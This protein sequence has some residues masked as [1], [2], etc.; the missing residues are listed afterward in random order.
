MCR[1]RRKPMHALFP[2]LEIHKAYKHSKG[3]SWGIGG[4]K[5]YIEE[6][7]RHKDIIHTLTTQ[8]IIGGKRARDPAAKFLSQ[9][10]Y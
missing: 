6:A 8:H 2:Y 10:F 7:R 1:K 3:S 4:G 9:T 5:N